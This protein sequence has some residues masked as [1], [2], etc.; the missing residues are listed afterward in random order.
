MDDVPDKIPKPK[1]SFLV[2]AFDVK[3]GGKRPLLF[4]RGG[5]GS[6]SVL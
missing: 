5:Y 2:R 1:P 3:D 4:F 6:F